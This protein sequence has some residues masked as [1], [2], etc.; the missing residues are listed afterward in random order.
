MSLADGGVSLCDRFGYH[1]SAAADTCLFPSVKPCMFIL[2]KLHKVHRGFL[3]LSSFVACVPLRQG[4][5]ETK[6][7][8]FSLIGTVQTECQTALFIEEIPRE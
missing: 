7:L 2:I 3:I 4:G 8:L 5:I 6:H 1:R